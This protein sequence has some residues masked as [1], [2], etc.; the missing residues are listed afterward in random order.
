MTTTETNE[1]APM[2]EAQ[3]RIGDGESAL[4]DT[5]HEADGLEWQRVDGR[6]RATWAEAK[7]YAAGLKL[8]GG[9]WRLPTK[10]E[11]LKT[12]GCPDTRYVD[13]YWTTTPAG[14]PTK[15]REFTYPYGHGAETYSPSIGLYDVRCVRKSAKATR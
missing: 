3:L 11:A 9:G 4:P 1:S 10:K 14:A 15:R 13:L 7:A 12:I 8:D 6:R 2:D 5:Y